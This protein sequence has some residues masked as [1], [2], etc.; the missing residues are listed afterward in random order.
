[1]NIEGILIA[2]LF[3]AMLP[4]CDV[5]ADDASQRESAY[6][7]CMDK[8]RGSPLTASMKPESVS[9]YCTCIS[10]KSVTFMNASPILQ[11]AMKNQDVRQVQ[12]FISSPEWQNTVA[13][14]GRQCINEVEGSNRN[15]KN[16]IRKDAPKQPNT[17]LSE[18]SRKSF[19]EGYVSECTAAMKSSP[20][21]RHYQESSLREICA[22]AA[23]RIATKLTYAD[24]QKMAAKD[25]P[26][27]TRFQNAA[28]RH[29]VT[30]TT[31]VLT[32]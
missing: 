9:Q 30:C 4:K 11:Q 21:G 17:P 29:L 22:C 6:R 8:Q 27:V 13:E 12:Q 7:G 15:A 28:E 5:Y 10:N 32:Q 18:E 24:V 26:T 1:M 19:M 2:G 23:E 25:S 20:K 3:L 16:L 31:K 14:Y